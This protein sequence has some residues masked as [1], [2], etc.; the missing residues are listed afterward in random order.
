MMPQ[1]QRTL[2]MTPLVESYLGRR[3]LPGETR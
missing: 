3:G 1:H 2:A